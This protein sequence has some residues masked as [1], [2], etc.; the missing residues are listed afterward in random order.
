MTVDVLEAQRLARQAALDAAKSHTERNRLGQYA[1][2]TA[3]ATHILE[4]ARHLLSQDTAIRF[5][6]P[7]LGT[8]AFY[9]AL[10]RVFAASRIEAATGC[11]I[12]PHY[13]NAARQLWQNCPLEVVIE[14]FTTV[15]PPADETSRYNLIVCNP[16]YVRHHHLKS[17]DK[18]RLQSLVQSSCDIHLSGLSGLYVY[19]LIL[20]HRWLREG[21]IAGWLIPG[22]FMDVNYGAGVREYLT[23]RVTLLKI[24][25]FDPAEVQFDDALVSSTVV[26][27]RNEKPAPEHRV[28]FS[29]GSVRQTIALDDLKAAHKWSRFPGKPAR[30]VDRGA[31]RI[32]DLFDIKR[33]VATGANQF[34]ILD[35]AHPLTNTL[36]PVFLTPILPGPRH[37]DSDE[38]PAD[39][40]G[41]PDIHHRLFLLTCDL[42]EDD[43]QKSYPELWDYLQRGRA[44]GIHQR[45][46]CRQRSL[47]YAQDRR[48][49]SP[50]LCTYMG[51]QSNG[52]SPFRFILNHSR[53]IVPN[54]YLNMYPKAWL[55]PLLDDTLKAAIWRS[56]Q[57]IPPEKLIGEGRVYGG[58]LYK[59]EPKELGHLPASDVFADNPAILMAV[60]RQKRLF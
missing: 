25:R 43:I 53:A 7:A 19:F 22:E 33:G 15:A 12:D 48:E 17:E 55:R 28:I 56:L 32:T 47:W 8:G 6:D 13:A 39:S 14:D 4:Q 45:Y 51:R 11:E 30:T 49:P 54:V 2:P 3:L 52:G 40:E 38:I 57:A 24:H 41:L 20:A 60:P 10:L 46:L 44:Q 58:G 59:L 23:S 37:L 9:S 5:L 50:F 29:Q 42:P 31:I 1:T 36:P 21:G 34:F 16:P 27:I 26:W 35:G 18:K